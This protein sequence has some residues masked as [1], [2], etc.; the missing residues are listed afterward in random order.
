MG[1][2]LIKEVKGPRK[3]RP[4][5]RREGLAGALN[6]NGRAWDAARLPSYSSNV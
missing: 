2:T 1:T 4:P 6:Q 3:M 5:G